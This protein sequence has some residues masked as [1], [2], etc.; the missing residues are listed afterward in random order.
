MANSLKVVNS[1]FTLQSEFLQSLLNEDTVK[2]TFIIQL[3]EL[4]S[5]YLGILHKV[6]FH[7]IHQGN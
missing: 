1:M 7:H 5:T 3:L 6:H 2:P 4:K